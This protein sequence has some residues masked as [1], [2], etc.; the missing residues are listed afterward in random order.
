[1]DIVRRNTDYALRAMVNLAKHHRAGYRSTRVIAR[2]E[3]IS[4]Q[5]ACKLLQKLHDAGLVESVMGPRGGFRLA[6]NPERVSLLEV[7]ETIQGPVRLNRCLLDSGECPRS[8]HCPVHEK[9]VLLQEQMVAFMSG[10]TLSDV[11]GNGNGQLSD[12]SKG[13]RL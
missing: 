11:C 5:L 6:R 2:E 12:E 10:T 13:G 9:F 1:M 3:E 7:I 8:P 4:Y